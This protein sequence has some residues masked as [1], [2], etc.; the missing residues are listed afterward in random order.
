M[1]ENFIMAKCK[2]KGSLFEKRERGLAVSRMVRSAT[3]C[4]KQN[5]APAK[6]GTAFHEATT[7]AIAYFA[8]TRTISNTLLE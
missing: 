5:A 4:T 8:M 6:A 3:P 2:T 7:G 1:D